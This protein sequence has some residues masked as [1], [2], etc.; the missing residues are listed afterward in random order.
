MYRFTIL[1]KKELRVILYSLKGAFQVLFFLLISG[2]FFHSFVNAF[3][4]MSRDVSL[5]GAERPDLNNLVQAM[6]SNF[7]FI[8][9][10]LIPAS[11]MGS[12][13][14]E[15]SKKTIRIFLAS[16]VSALEI[17]LSKFIAYLTFIGLTLALSSLYFGYINYYGNPDMNIVITSYIGLVLLSS[18]HISLGIFI[19]SLFHKQI[20]SF[21]VSMMLTLGL[22]VVTWASEKL[23]VTESFKNFLSYLGTATHVDPFY[24]GLLRLSDVIYFVSFTAIFLTLAANELNRKEWK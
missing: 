10:L 3:T 15:K 8:L 4:E 18:A 21:L 1:L 16:P 5:Y 12:I 24:T 7:Q 14:E 9:L 17:I 11:T 13:S 20:L 2:I 19:S 22:S 23:L 6:F